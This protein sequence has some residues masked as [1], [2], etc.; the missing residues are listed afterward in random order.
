MLQAAET[1]EQKGRRLL[2]DALQALGG[3]KFA[4]LQDTVATGFSG[5]W[6]DQKPQTVRTRVYSL[7]TATGALERRA[8]EKNE[9]YSLLFNEQGGFE[10]TFRGS[11]PVSEEQLAAH[12]RDTHNGVFHILRYRLREPGLQVRFAGYEVCDKQS[13][14]IIEIASNNPDDPLVRVC[15]SQTT[16]LPVR[17]SYWRRHLL[18][19]ERIEEVTVF[20]RYQAAG[21][22]V[23]LPH[24]ISRLRDGEPVLDLFFEDIAVNQGLTPEQFA[25]RARDQPAPAVSWRFRP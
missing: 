22:G 11:R 25:I 3:G 10:I 13:G 17:Q 18:T 20:A 1:A 21:D 24:Q 2:E 4:R 23:L 6:R 7:F 15:L 9:L 19:R 8:Y 12:R 16:H 5:V 14:D